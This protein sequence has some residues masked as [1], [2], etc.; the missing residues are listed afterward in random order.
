MLCIIN[1]EKYHR[2]KYSPF[3]SKKNQS[4]Y[5]SDSTNFSECANLVNHL[6]VEGWF[7][8]RRWHNVL[9]AEQVEISWNRSWRDISA[10]RPPLS[11]RYSHL[12]P[13]LFRPEVIGY[14]TDANTPSPSLSFTARK[15]IIHAGFSPPPPPPLLFLDWIRI[16]RKPR[17]KSKQWNKWREREGSQTIYDS[18]SKSMEDHSFILY[19]FL[20]E[21]I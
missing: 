1:L 15:S 3:P 7:E 21:W 14:I 20:L 18:S 2:R 8:R 13:A 12:L 17:K 11:P 16:A 6:F 9:I 4:L 10:G 5:R 19:F